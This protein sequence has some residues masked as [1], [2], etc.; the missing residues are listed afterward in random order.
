VARLKVPAPLAALARDTRTP[1]YYFDESKL[2]DLARHW[3]RAAKIGL[4]IFYPYKCNRF[5]GILDSF[6]REGFGAEINIAA[7]LNE[8]R[9][10]GIEGDRLLMHGP[11]KE[12]DAIDRVLAAGGS[13]AVDSIADGNAVLERSFAIGRR[14]RYLLRIRAADAREGQRAFGM[15][16]TDIARFTRVAARGGR[17]LPAGLAFHLGT[18]ISTV[19]PYR[20]SIRVAA[21]LARVQKNS[22]APVSILD[23]GGGFPSAGETRFDDRG[24]PHRTSWTDPAVIARDLAGEARRRL[25]DV[26]VWIEPG[27]ALV[28]D[29]F[30]LVTRVVRVRAGRDV[31][32][33]GSRMAHGFFIAR[34]SHPVVLIPSRR[35][36]VLPVVLAGPLGTDLDVFVRRLAAVPPREGDVLVFGNVGA[37]NLIAANAWAGAIPPVK[38]SGDAKALKERRESEW[39]SRSSPE[40]RSS[41]R[42]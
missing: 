35:G 5:P 11:V 29:A 8:A 2:R 10:R 28:A 18:G 41:P 17:P 37:Y 14:P 12:P 36:K 22:G 7:D 13:F 39:S 20:T 26:E 38:T 27:R 15:T 9:I 4:K 32:V 30:H 33:D 19:A 24:R 21:K 31:F 6:A 42:A 1:F 25:G 16:P 3:R 34:G 40:P 23:V